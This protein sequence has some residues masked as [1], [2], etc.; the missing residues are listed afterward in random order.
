MLEKNSNFEKANLNMNI[1]FELLKNKYS[2]FKKTLD[3]SVVD[4]PVSKVTT[5]TG[6][7]EST[8]DKNLV[9][10]S[11][12]LKSLD[13]NIVEQPNDLKLLYKN[14]EEQPDELKN[15]DLNVKSETEDQDNLHQINPNPRDVCENSFDDTKCIDYC[16]S[17]AGLRD[18][19]CRKNFPDPQVNCLNANN[20]DERLKCLKNNCNLG[21]NSDRSFCTFSQTLNKMD[22]IRNN[23]ISNVNQYK[24]PLEQ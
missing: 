16:Y 19:F 24:N 10:Q 4:T 23:I 21:Y 22:K 13:N 18:K 5:N 2:T 11:D 9:E 17:R 12:E 8:L 14:A 7:L 1:K 15:L 20:N 3:K 6:S